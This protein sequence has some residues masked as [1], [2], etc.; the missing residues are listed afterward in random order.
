MSKKVFRRGALPLALAA[1][2]L[3]GLTSGC[4]ELTDLQDA[5]CCSD[6]DVGANLTD[7]DF[8]ANAQFDAWIQGVADFS[9]VASATVTDLAATCR[10]LALDLG[11]DDDGSAPADPGE[12]AKFWCN[13]AVAQIQAEVTAR[14]SIS[15]TVQPPICNVDVNVSASCEGSCQVD[16]SCDPGG[17]EVRCDPGKLAGKCEGSCSGSCQ[18]SANLA[19]ACEGTC[20]GTCTGECNGTCSTMM[21]N[22]C[23]GSCDGTCTGECRGTCAVDASADIECSGECSGGCDVELKAPKCQGEIEP[24]MCDVDADCQASCDAS[25]SAKAECKPPAIELVATG[26][27]SVQAIGALKLHLPK[28]FLIAEVRADQLLASGQ[29]LLDLS[30]KLDPG[31]LSGKAALCVIPAASAIGSAFANVEASVSASA[32]IVGEIG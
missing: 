26:D 9:G 28:L 18:G 10:G 15:V 2:V 4:E 6:F 8:E 1:L 23:N 30:V 24:P 22:T 17:V 20:E 3:P 27:I 11:G 5:L 32:S 21:G 25:A 19:V 13:A 16:A 12:A 31:E 14:G 29:A 7:V